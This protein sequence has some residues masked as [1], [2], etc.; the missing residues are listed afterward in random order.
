MAPNGFEKG[1]EEI[2]RDTVDKIPV[3]PIND[4][5]I[6]P[7]ISVPM[8][9]TEPEYASLLDDAII[10]GNPIA[11]VARKKPPE[12][13]EQKIDVFDVG[14][15]AKVLKMLRFPD[16]SVRILLQGESRFILKSILGALP[17]AFADYEIAEAEPLNEVESEALIRSLREHLQNISGKV[18]YL[19]D[20]L[21]QTASHIK[22][23]GALADMIAFNL[24][25]STEAKQT[26]LEAFDIAERVRLIASHI[27]RELQVI[28]L[29]QQIQQDTKQE[30]G[31]LQREYIL[32]EQMKVIQRELGEGDDRAAEVENYRMKIKE[33]GLSEEAIEVANSE[34]DRFSR[35]NPAAA[36]YTV[37][38]TYLDWL[39]ALPWKKQTYD[40]LDL[41][42]AKTILDEDHYGLEKVKDRILEYLAVRKLNPDIKGPILCFVGPPGVGK[43]SLGMSIARSMGRKFYRM[44]LG[45]MRDEAEIRGH[46][47]TYVGAMPGRILQA[48]RK[49]QSNNPVVMLDELDKLGNDFRGDPSSAL[50]EV[51]DP[52]QNHT[53]SD[54]YLEVPFDLSKIF[55]LGTANLM[56]PIPPAL[57]DRMELIYLPGY[58]D[59][60]KLSIARKYVLPREIENNGLSGDLIDFSDKAVMKLINDY[61]RE[62]GLR[63]LTREVANICRKVARVIAEGD[64]NRVKVTP[65]KVSQYLGPEKFMREVSAEKPQIGIV[66][67]L[68]Y[69]SVGGEILFI[70]ATKMPGGKSL[71]LTG[72]IG[73]VMKE[74]M[75]AALS[76]IRSTS[77]MWG[78]SPEI[79]DAFD[80]HIHVPAGATPKDGPS[81]GV[82]IATALL[83]ILTDKPVKP[84]LAMTGEITLRG[85]VLPVGGIK[86]KC[87]GA[88]RAGIKTVIL[89]LHNEK[90]LYELPREV[91][92]AMKFIPVSNIEEVFNQVLQEQEPDN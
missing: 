30:M 65:K 82:A 25:I 79:F 49:V 43:T 48:L 35:M 62:A 57:R 26:I 52:E 13:G 9:I 10:N 81:A 31:K 47:R 37:S 55:F 7:G 6:Y 41:K 90:D 18:E 51:L 16:G 85:E 89:P 27:N 17:Q 42:K 59:M 70:E 28:E 73:N 76:Y 88:F 11:V 56:E 74:S 5:V 4:K 23:P 34:L 36:E 92:K 14:C 20:E 12:G 64:S 53:F 22:D 72:H 87:L 54:H 33:A 15:T 46:R 60:E 39:I 58:T 69:T 45:G 24:K 91:M 67:G 29:S 86:E 50:L 19:P 32:R 63:N 77:P 1:I 71:T 2:Q 68:A 75:Q 8:V 66:P 78:V 80:F 40:S 61:T 44:S 84:H 21:T 3:L 38:R 83:S